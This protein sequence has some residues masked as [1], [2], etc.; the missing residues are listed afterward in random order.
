MQGWIDVLFA[1]KN[2][3]EEATKLLK[4]HKEIKDNEKFKYVADM[5]Y[6]S[7]NIFSDDEKK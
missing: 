4:E 3:I 5:N 2:A 7:L 1:I 6:K